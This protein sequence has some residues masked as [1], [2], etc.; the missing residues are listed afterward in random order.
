MEIVALIISIV[1]IIIAIMA[2]SRTG[3]VAD[4]KKRVEALTD[5]GETIISKASDSLRDKTAD[6]LGKV[7]DAVRGEEEAKEKPKTSQKKEQKK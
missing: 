4:L 1:A 5:A 3:G 7:E 6:V 2:Y